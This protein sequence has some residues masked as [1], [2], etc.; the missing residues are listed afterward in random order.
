VGINRALTMFGND[1]RKLTAGAY[2][3]CA[4]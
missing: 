4:A 2:A 3:D 1:P